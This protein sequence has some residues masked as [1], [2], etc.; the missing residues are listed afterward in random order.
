MLAVSTKLYI[1][2]SRSEGEQWGFELDSM[3]IKEVR[4]GSTLANWNWW[5]PSRAVVKGDQV[6]DVNGKSESKAVLEMMKSANTLKVSLMRLGTVTTFGVKLIRSSESRL[7][8]KLSEDL[9]V[10][11]IDKTGALATWNATSPLLSVHLGDRILQIAQLTSPEKIFRFLGSSS[12]PELDVVMERSPRRLDSST[13]AIYTQMECEAQLG[14]GQWQHMQPVP[15]APEPERD[16]EED[17]MKVVSDNRGLL[18]SES[19]YRPGMLS[20]G[21]CLP[22]CSCEDLGGPACSPTL[23]HRGRARAQ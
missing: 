9:Q 11:R 20:F 4:D 22:M 23:G 10:I 13:G 16:V 15:D 18:A 19:F 12:D 14:K 7:G 6:L 17:A 2:L 3:C 8:F 1:E 5:H 21:C